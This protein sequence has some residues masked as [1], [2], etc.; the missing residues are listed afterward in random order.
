MSDYSCI[1]CIPQYFVCVCTHM[2][3]SLAAT[4]LRVVQLNFT[5]VSRETPFSR[6]T[7]E[8]CVRET[9]LLLFRA[10]AAEKNVFLTFKGIGVLSFKNN[11]VAC[12][13][14]L[15]G[16]MITFSLQHG[17]ISAHFKGPD[18]IQQRFY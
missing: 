16:T 2:C 18:E 11:K 4:H 13:F 6:D 10:L 7:V 9:L 5:A 15:S 17:L 14:I 12:L 8:G 3:V 1:V